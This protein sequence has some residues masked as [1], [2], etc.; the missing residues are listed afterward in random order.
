MDLQ[1][2][3]APIHFGSDESLQ[4]RGTTG[5]GI[6]MPVLD[7]CPVPSLPFE[8]G[9]IR[10]KGRWQIWEGDSGLLAVGSMPAAGALAPLTR[11]LYQEA[12]EIA[13][14]LHLHR[15]WNFVPGINQPT[16]GLE[17]YRSFGT[18][19]YEAFL[20]R[21]GRTA[22]TRMPAAS[23]VGTDGDHLVVCMIAGSSEP[24]HFENPEQTPAYRYPDLFGPRP[25]SFS[26]ASRV[27]LAGREV[28][29]IAGTASIRGYSSVGQGDLDLQ[30]ETILGNL[31]AL[32]SR[33]GLPPGLGK[34]GGFSRSF[35][36]YLRHRE[37]LDVV[38]ER[39]SASL[40][41][42][43]DESTWLRSDICR[44]DLDV[45]IEATLVDRRSER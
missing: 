24:V 16:D 33:M 23:G 7:G 29:F 14:G 2:E 3:S 11:S 42:P 25:P 10:R 21:F 45:E 4:D 30:M 12:F 6:A 17:N 43:T 5:V 36:V 18:G 41:E 44:S 19:R 20:D 28:S 31:E 40:I 39:F 37:H 26:R 22:S 34:A 35:R 32:G 8:V 38:R 1:T 15:F 9:R 13:D 27:K